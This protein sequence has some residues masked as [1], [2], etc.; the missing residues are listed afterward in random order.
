MS[1][2]KQFK[3]NPSE[4]QE[5][6]GQLVKEWKL[7][8]HSLVGE[9]DL[10]EKENFPEERIQELNSNQIQHLIKELSQ[11]RQNLNRELEEIKD[12]LDFALEKQENLKLVGSDVTELES[13]IQELYNLGEIISDKLSKIDDRLKL[14]RS[15][16]GDLSKD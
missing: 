4:R 12:D 9:E 6:L 16:P 14:V 10:D 1:N 13:E 3:K 15:M 5:F 7:F 11:S 8:W 2:D